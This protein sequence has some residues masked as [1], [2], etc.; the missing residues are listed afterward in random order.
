MGSV[1]VFGIL[2]VLSLRLGAYMY[3]QRRRNVREKRIL[4]IAEEARAYQRDGWMRRED[5]EDFL[6][7]YNTLKND[8]SRAE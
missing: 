5:Y 1:W 4:E 8:T 7:A 6:A 2:V 3:F